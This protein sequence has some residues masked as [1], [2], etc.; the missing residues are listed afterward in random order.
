MAGHSTDQQTG[1][2]VHT[3]THPCNTHT[4]RTR[5]TLTLS[6]VLSLVQTQKAPTLS[7]GAPLHRPPG[8]RRGQPASLRP[9]SP[10]PRARRRVCPA[11]WRH[12]WFQLAAERAFPSQTAGPCQGPGP[13]GAHK[14]GHL[15]PTPPLALLGTPKSPLP[16]KTP[17]SSSE[18]SAHLEP[19]SARTRTGPGCAR[20]AATAAR[21]PPRSCSVSSRLSRMGGGQGVRGAGGREGR[22]RVEMKL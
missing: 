6:D 13:G 15:A 20:A 22:G 16:W 4:H 17:P 11:A 10:E 12:M 3:H 21:L 14:K 18:A 7:K 5:T 19:A 8:T 1:L 9:P 2:H